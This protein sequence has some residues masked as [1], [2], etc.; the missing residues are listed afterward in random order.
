MPP[1]YSFAMRWCSSVPAPPHVPG[2][3]PT[4]AQ[5]EQWT[6]RLAQHRGLRVLLTHGM[7]DA[8]LPFQCTGWTQQLLQQNGAKVEYQAHTGGHELGGQEVIQALV[9]FVKESVPE[10]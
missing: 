1:P 9:K 8:T 2:G 10:S 7:Q 3:A 5:V 4:P 6:E